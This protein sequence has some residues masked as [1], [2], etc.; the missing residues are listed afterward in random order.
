MSRKDLDQTQIKH[1]I[2]FS[3]RWLETTAYAHQTELSVVETNC[4]S[5]ITLVVWKRDKWYTYWKGLLVRTTLSILV[6]SL[7]HIKQNYLHVP[8]ITLR[9]NVWNFFI[10]TYNMNMRKG[11]STTNIFHTKT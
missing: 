10:G 11:Q 9:K 4:S 6:V 3:N 1:A 5:S 8:N 7:R 2:F